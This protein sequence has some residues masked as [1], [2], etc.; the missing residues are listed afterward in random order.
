MFVNMLRPVMG[1]ATARHD[2]AKIVSDMEQ[3][4]CCGKGGSI[5]DVFM[6]QRALEMLKSLGHDGNYSN[7]CM[8]GDRYGTDIR[9]ATHVGLRSCLV[10]SGCETLLDR[11]RYPTDRASY[12]AESVAYMY[13]R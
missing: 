8:I 3:F 9:A 5:G 13:P 12:W 4:L 10:L 1:T 6:M 2:G 11:V 7:V